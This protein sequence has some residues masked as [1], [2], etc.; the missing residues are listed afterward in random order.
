MKIRRVFEFHGDV[1]RLIK[2]GE[3]TADKLRE[4]SVNV[5]EQ[6]RREMRCTETRRAL[7]ETEYN[8][9]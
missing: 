2:T 6:K 7:R 3:I 9:T 8:K 4:A 5:G 1:T